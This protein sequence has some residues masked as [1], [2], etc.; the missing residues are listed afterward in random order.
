MPDELRLSK[1]SLDLWG[2]CNYAWMLAYVY[3]IKGAPTLHMIQGRAVHAGIEAHWKGEDAL[4][5]VRTAFAADVASVPD[6]DPAMAVEALQEAV[7]L[8]S[9][10]VAKIA[11]T[12]TPK[13]VEARFLIRVNGILV[14]GA[15]D[16][17]DDDVHDTKSTST[18]SKVDPKRHEIEM[19][20]YH[21]G[22]E[23]LTGKPPGKLLLD[24]VGR[25]GRAATKEVA[26]DRRGA[27]EYLG[28]VAGKIN[29]GE[30]EPTGART[31][32]CVY[33]PYA[34]DNFCKYA[35]V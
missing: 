25:N 13:L 14:S 7:G 32:Q 29:A 26:E 6:V 27:A 11:P 24:I 9:T 31:G 19:S 18:P 21:M 35:R 34:V 4:E 30:F 10:Y 12:F 3:R 28:Y 23:A 15:I 20:I 33:C 5:R 22:F 8:V 2:D 17:A 1:S 16:A